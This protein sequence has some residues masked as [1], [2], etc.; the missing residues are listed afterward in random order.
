MRQLITAF[1]TLA[2]LALPALAEPIVEANTAV[3]EPGDSVRVA[4]IP[5]GIFLRDTNDPADNIWSRLPEYRVHLWPAPA[6]HPSIDLIVDYDDP[7]NIVYLNLART[8]DRFYVR[9]RW[10]DDT[11][12]A[13]TTMDRFSDAAAIQFSLGDDATSYLMGTGPNDA[14][15]IWY[16]RADGSPAQNLAAG[17]YG[18]TT[19]L[20]T[21]TVSGAG[22]YREHET[23][24]NE[25]VVVMS[26]PLA[27]SGE[28][29]TSF[30]R[31]EVPA[32]FAI[33]QGSERQRDGNKLVSDGWILLDMGEG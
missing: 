6:V 23:A 11:H 26:R 33:W 32:A 22:T 27:V 14:V 8:S 25:W 20:P 3:L 31:F 16:W 19:M 30:R 13:A 1:G 10:R 21:Q 17:G 12:D 7:G 28:Y 18:S 15:N 24:P 29:E 9:M 4:T 2:T 5:D